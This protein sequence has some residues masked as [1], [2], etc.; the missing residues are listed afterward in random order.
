MS[1]GSLKWRMPLIA[2]V[3]A[4]CIFY[5]WPPFDQGPGKPGKIKLGL[6]LKGGM[7]LI[8]RV[9]TSKLPEKG[10]EDAAARHLGK[11]STSAT[12]PGGRS[13]GALRRPRRTRS[14][15]SI[16]SS[17]RSSRGWRS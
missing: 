5:A 10:K 4:V 9:D 8:L 12:E 2:A 15:P 3:V 16:P 13:A 14:A 11:P 7:H 1:Q 6:D 17:W